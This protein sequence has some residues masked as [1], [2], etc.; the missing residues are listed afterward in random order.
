MY[1]AMRG[2][3]TANVPLINGV[4]PPNELF[5]IDRRKVVGLTLDPERLVTYR[6][7]REKN[8]G[9]GT[10]ISYSDP[11]QIVRD[12]EF[13]HRIVRRGHFASIDVSNKPIEESANEVV[14]WVGA[15]P[16]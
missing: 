15:P 7:S 11:K 6:R 16:G 2:Y 4:E 9:S 5:E 12:V 10:S 8:M 3:R 13:A 1:L 14:A